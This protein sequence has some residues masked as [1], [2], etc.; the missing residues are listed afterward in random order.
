M[1]M[2]YMF[3]GRRLRGAFLA[4]TA[5]LFS[6]APVADDIAWDPASGAP[7]IFEPAFLTQKDYNEAWE[8]FFHFGDGA[9]VSLQMSVFN[10]GKGD[11]RTL[12]IGK[13]TT[14][15]G[16]ELVLK[17]GRSRDRWS[18]EPGKF[19]LRVENHHFYRDGD[20][21][22]LVIKNVNG[23]IEITGT[24]VMAPWDIGYTARQK[25]RRGNEDFQYVSVF[26][27]RM[28]ATGRYRLSPE[29]REDAEGEPWIDLPAGTGMGLRQVT[30]MDLAKLLKAWIRISP[31]QNGDTSDAN[32]VMPVFNLFVSN[33]DDMKHR[34]ALFRDDM[35]VTGEIQFS[36]P[37]LVDLPDD[38]TDCCDIS[39]PV[40][41]E[42][43]GRKVKGRI[44]LTSHIQSFRLVDVLST[45]DRFLARFKK[46]PVH[47]RF[48]IDYDLVIDADGI[49][50]HVTGTG[51]ADRVIFK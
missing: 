34:A 1:L 29:G 24:P 41:A 8:F 38:L 14:P 7:P 31:I 46:S 27:P 45:G 13:L 50:E 9:F 4:L 30:S 20:D 18:Y 51:F 3:V 33:G 17:N 36:T 47:N 26:A 12:V 19:D 32:G 40:S 25:D 44:D 5:C 6:M 21:F 37:V 2:N 11:H 39:I 23:E 42:G 28:V 15:E 16:T 48:M 49:Q 35:L 22:K 10:I 43:L